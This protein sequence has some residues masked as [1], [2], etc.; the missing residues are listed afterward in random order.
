MLGAGEARLRRFGAL[1]RFHREAAFLT[2]EELADR[3][4]L[5]VRTI[6]DM[7]RGKS[8]RPY[9]RSVRLLSEA[10]GLHPG[11]Q[12]ELLAAARP[13]TAPAAGLPV[14]AA[15]TAGAVAVV[16]RQLPA[17]PRLYVGGAAELA[18]L[19]RTLGDVSRTQAPATA[20]ISGMAGIGKTALAL[21]FARQAS[22]HFP[23]GQL[24][25]NL[26]GFG[27]GENP[28]DPAAA[29]G[30]FLRS[31]GLSPAQ[32][33]AGLQAR[34][35]LYRS[36]L[37]TRRVII[38]LDNARDEQQA[39]PLLPGGGANMAVVTSRRR[40]DGLAALEG[41]IPLDL[42]VLNEQD[43]TRLL[44][45]RLEADGLTAEP[46]AV[47]ELASLCGRLP[48]ALVV[49]GAQ[50]AAPRENSLADFTTE[51]R[52][53][54]NKLDVLDLDDATASLR[55]VFACSCTSLPDQAA[56]LF[57]ILSVH[58]GPSIS[59]PAAASLAGLTQRETLPLLR[60]LTD[61]HLLNE[62]QHGHFSFHDLLRAYA[63][64][65]AAQNET[66]Q[67]LAACRARILDHYLHTSYRGA[68]TRPPAHNPWRLRTGD[69]RCG[70]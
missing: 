23:D 44:R 25:I 50:A 35:A 12:A 42:S 6:S 62:H 9:S 47:S 54:R 37:S 46:R 52:R 60:T 59:V 3:T 32:I 48:L 69:T 24:Y 66:P 21:T 22:P 39:R 56:R 18:A 15:G 57:R 26:Q 43:A 8:T 65:I 40:L 55:A 64:E 2:Q 14:I 61:S 49:A 17:S 20:M 29:L 33:P 11:A 38:V 10:L 31:L 53:A 1:L 5:S 51:L 13:G 19:N 41:I 36:L 16:P 30:T 4:G 7:E 27:P 63:A 68:G 45:S 67:D 34:A 70:A 58:P 28:L